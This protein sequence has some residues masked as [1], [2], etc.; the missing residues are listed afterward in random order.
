MSNEC[1]PLVMCGPSGV[2]KTTLK[3][4][5]MAKY[6]GKFGFSVSHTTRPPRTGEADGV[7]YNFST[8]EIM[9]KMI[10]ED[11]FVEYANV[12]L[13]IYGTSIAAVRK[14]MEAGK[15]CI[16]DID[17]QGVNTIMNG[18]AHKELKPFY[19]FVQPKTFDALERR[20][21][22][23]ATDTE[24]QIQTRLNTAKSEIEASK[25][26]PFDYYLTNHSLE[27]AFQN[28][29]AYMQK[30]YPSLSESS[31]SKPESTNRR[32]RV[33]GALAIA[34]AVVAGSCV[35]KKL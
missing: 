19:M 20:L 12:H 22:S 23:R 7:D 6:P 14:V 28:Y 3:E 25:S 9:L 15:I 4:M 1:R 5:L 31:S 24:E 26:V 34:C 18:N 8:K 29:D 16:L 21:R 33:R 10:A 17:I 30:C 11:K 2:G 32:V 27:K 13:N 35:L